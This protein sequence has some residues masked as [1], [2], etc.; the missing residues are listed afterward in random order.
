MSREHGR[1]ACASRAT[2]G[3]ELGALVGH[4]FR[5][6]KLLILKPSSLSKSSNF[7]A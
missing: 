3:S 2:G 4:H 1:F 5:T 7:S 6:L